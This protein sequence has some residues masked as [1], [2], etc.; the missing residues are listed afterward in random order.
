[1]HF[2]FANLWKK[3]ENEKASKTVKKDEE[4]KWHPKTKI[5]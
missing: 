2:T 3:G 5:A 1:V 4:K